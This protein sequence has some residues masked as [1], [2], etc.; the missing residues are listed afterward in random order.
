MLYDYGMLVHLFMSCSSSGKHHDASPAGR[1]AFVR[2]P[3]H[4]YGTQPGGD[5]AQVWKMI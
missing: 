1:D 2:F 3:K 4:V 5:T